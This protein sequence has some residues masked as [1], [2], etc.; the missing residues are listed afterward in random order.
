MHRALLGPYQATVI[1]LLWEDIGAL[2]AR[3]PDRRY[4][5]KNKLSRPH[6]SSCHLLKCGFAGFVASRS[7][8]PPAKPPLSLAASSEITIHLTAHR[9]V[10]TTLAR[11]NPPGT[12]DA[13]PFFERG[14]SW[15]AARGSVASRSEITIHQTAAIPR[16]LLGDHDP[17]NGP[18]G[19]CYNAG[20]RKSAGDGGHYTVLR[21]GRSWRAAR[22]SVAS[23]SARPPAKP[24][25]SPSASSE[26]SIYLTAHRAVA[27]TLAR[28][29][30]SGTA[31]ATHVLRT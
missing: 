22:G 24:P 28:G 2:L 1:L 19:R 17:P 10:A 23:R 4:S 15:R 30:P 27:T 21:T 11:G 12:T 18:Q 7:A 3:P 14:R 5:S 25:L 26:I 16:R 29:N 6:L 8:L 9:A 20:A 31:D 13:T